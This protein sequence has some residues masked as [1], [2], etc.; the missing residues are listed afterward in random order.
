MQFYKQS[1]TSPTAASPDTAASAALA[2]APATASG[3]SFVSAP[4]A[5]TVSSSSP[6]AA[7]RDTSSVGDRVQFSGF[8]FT[9]APPRA[10]G[11]AFNNRSA[12][13]L[14]PAA[15]SGCSFVSAPAAAT[16]T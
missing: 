1:A 13:A 9:P 3:F 14:A 7:S 6:A 4:A 11:V 12:P 5:A 10:Q 8:N 16:V 15:A 2:L